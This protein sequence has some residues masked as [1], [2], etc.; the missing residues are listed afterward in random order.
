MGYHIVE[1]LK[2]IR[3]LEMVEGIAVPVP[4]FLY[5]QQYGRR[6]E[7]QMDLI[8]EGLNKKE[9]FLFKIDERQREKGM[10]QSLSVELE[11]RAKIGKQ[12]EECVLIEFGEG[13]YQQEA[14]EELFDYLKTMEDKVSFLFTVKPSKN[15]D[16]LQQCMEQYFFV[17]TIQ[18][19]AYTVEEQI[20]LIQ[21]HCERFR[22]CL[23]EKASQVFAEG[24]A[25]KQWKTYDH[26]ACRLKNLVYGF[27]YENVLE[28][29]D[30]ADYIT[31]EV[32][33]TILEQMDNEGSKKVTIGFKQGGYSYE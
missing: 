21:E 24:L 25:K 2:K 7:E 14:L 15:M 9:W 27:L 23:T 33:L 17:R 20:T 28:G 11:K 4:S 13:M 26:V 19:E 6:L 22:Y 8:A 5:I 31:S 12:Y 1:E 29:K 16:I 18:G 3:N 10:V 30:K 32:A